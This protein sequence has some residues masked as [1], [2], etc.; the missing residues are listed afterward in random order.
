MTL[1]G[2]GPAYRPRVR[3]ALAGI[4]LLGF[5]VVGVAAIAPAPSRLLRHW[6]ADTTIYPV[7]MLGYVALGVIAS[8]VSLTFP[9]VTRSP[10]PPATVVPA[11]V[12]PATMVVLAAQLAGLGIVAAKHWKPAF[13]MG[14]GYVGDPD[15]LA[16]L[17]W[18]V[19]LAG[20]VAAA[21]AVGQLVCLGVFRWRRADRGPRDPVR[22][23]ST[24][25]LVLGGT[26]AAILLLLPFG[27]A[28]GDP[29]AHDLTSLG[30][31]ALIYSA[32]LGVT[33]GASA[34]LV[35][36]LSAVATASCAV[37]AACSALGF[38]IDLNGEN[39]R[40]ALVVVAAVLAV[41]SL[42]VAWFAQRD[43]DD[44]SP[45]ESPLGGAG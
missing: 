38:M 37:A 23:S 11:T 13:G 18:I 15:Q 44:V 4:Q 16:R 45:R 3:R 25:G 36:R 14:G 7:W 6:G 35:G 20:L 19:G 32:P 10:D 24:E 2:H 39:S 1:S 26:G 43:A 31:F 9:N 40:P 28:L 21:A 17:A 5:A 12:V 30:A 22:L 33:V 27:V 8:I 29:D 42:G 41:V 34:L